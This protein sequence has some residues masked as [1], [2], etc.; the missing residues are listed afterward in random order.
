[1]M[2]KSILLLL[3]VFLVAV[4][5]VYAK[6]PVKEWYK[7]EAK[8]EDEYQ[9]YNEKWGYLT[10]KVEIFPGVP[11]KDCYVHPQ[12]HFH[13]ATK[14]SSDGFFILD[15]IPSG[16]DFFRVSDGKVTMLM[17]SAVVQPIQDTS[18]GT[19]LLP[20]GTVAGRIVGVDAWNLAKMVVTVEGVPLATKPDAYGNYLLTN[21]PMRNREIVLHGVWWDKAQPERRIQINVQANR[22]NDAPDFVLK[23]PPPPV[24]LQQ[25]PQPPGHMGPGPRPLPPAKVEPSPS[26]PAPSPQSSGRGVAPPRPDQEARP[27]ST[28]MGYCCLQGQVRYIPLE[29]CERKAGSIFPTLEEA[30]R[31]CNGGGGRR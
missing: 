23:L 17:F 14:C 16:M 24:Q 25:P 11:C 3:A 7:E 15:K 27:P 26:M 28:K 6:D 22:L 18:V 8:R 19:I 21:V 1:M 9:K 12:R 2:R 4:P 5:Q 13:P 31:N 29:E 20:T 10:G 30:K